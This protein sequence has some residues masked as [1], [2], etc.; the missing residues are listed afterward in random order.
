MKKM[1]KREIIILGIMGVVVLFGAF[2]LLLGKS[3]KKATSLSGLS[4]AELKTMT[5]ELAVAISRDMLSP[6][7]SYA[8]ARA[9]EEWLH[10]PFFERK[11]Y[12]EM[13]RSKELAKVVVDTSKKPTFRYTG[14]LEYG[15]RKVAI[16]NGW[17]YVAGE[18][19]ESKGYVLRSISPTQVTIEHI[20]DK[21]KI[22]V[23]IDDW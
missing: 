22:E 18:A 20:G 3:D 5:G 10:D 8:I 16:I 23:P 21:T 6:G 9:E 1:E 15:S 11:S 14:Y 13:L 7:E 17:E 4:P 12:H 2:S 19:L